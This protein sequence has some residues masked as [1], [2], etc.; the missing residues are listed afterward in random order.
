M[1]YEKLT[2]RI[3]YVAKCGLDDFED[4]RIGN[5]PRE[6]QCTKCGGWLKYEKQEWIGPDKIGG[7]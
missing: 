6:I 4:I 5:P 1:A 3:L 2:K 7:K